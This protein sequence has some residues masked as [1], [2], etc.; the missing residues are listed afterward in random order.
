MS[1]ILIAWELGT[2]YGHLARLLPIAC[3]LRERGHA[4]V[5]AVRDTHGAAELLLPAG[6]EFV[7]APL[8][9]SKSRLSR[10]A[11]NYPELLL[12]EGFADPSALAG[13][14]ASWRSLMHLAKTDIVLADHAPTALLAARISGVPHLAIGNGFTLPPDVSPLPSI[15]P[16]EDIPTSRLIAAGTAVDEA[17]SRVAK[18]LGYCLPITL[19]NLFGPQDLLDTFIELDHYSE[20]GPIN[21]IGP[22]FSIEGA[23]KVEWRETG[24]RKIFAYLRP[25]VRGFGAML[26]VLRETDAE[27]LCVA[28]GLHPSHARRLAGPRLR[29]SLAPLDLSPLLDSA[30]LAI[31]YGNSGTCAQALLAGTPVLALPQFVEQYLFGVRLQALGAGVQLTQDRGQDACAQALTTLLDDTRYAACARQIGHKYAGHT[32]KMA[33][34][35]A[36]LAIE[37]CTVLE[38]A[39]Y[40]GV[41]NG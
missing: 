31:T 21:A 3:R 27:T 28:P 29:I 40:R 18:R 1:R 9:F 12:G 16:W 20:R 13:R 2:N 8:P 17:I 11:A 24:S 32:P 26:A 34:E 38:N 6:L 22:I 39:Q 30:A 33:V 37:N 5:L 36:V 14:V 19:R 35:R 10:P 7:Q 15:R 41:L 25:N 23:R 4:V